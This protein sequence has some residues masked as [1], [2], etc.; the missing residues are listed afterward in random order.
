MTLGSWLHGTTFAEMRTEFKFGLSFKYMV[1]CLGIFYD[2]PHLWR[3]MTLGSWLHG[4]TFAEMRT[5]FKF[6]LSF[7]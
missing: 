5:E 4:T 7:K 1:G 3:K 6:G 2:F